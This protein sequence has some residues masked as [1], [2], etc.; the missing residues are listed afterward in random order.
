MEPHAGDADQKDLEPVPY[1]LPLHLQQDLRL[2][3]IGRRQ[4]QDH[5]PR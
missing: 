5:Q 3:I 2:S 4:D 1:Y